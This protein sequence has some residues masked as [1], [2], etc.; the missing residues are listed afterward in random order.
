[1][2]ELDKLDP[3][4]QGELDPLAQ[5]ITFTVKPWAITIRIDDYP[6]RPPKIFVNKIDYSSFLQK[7]FP[8]RYDNLYYRLCGRCCVICT[9]FACADNWH[10][11][12]T[13]KH[14]INEFE[15]FILLKKQ[16]V[17]IYLLEQVMNRFGVPPELPI[18]S[19]LH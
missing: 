3:S 13:F 18:L 19:F 6:F 4:Y 16:M 2:K 1:M 10:C 5:E 7:M 14:I 11:S 8:K 17:T 12:V 15:R 9:S